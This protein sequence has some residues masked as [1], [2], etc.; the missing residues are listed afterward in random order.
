ML[1]AP[2]IKR[3][4]AALALL[5]LMAA[6]WGWLAD[7]RPTWNAPIS[8]AARYSHSSFDRWVAEDR[9]RAASFRDFEAFLSANGV[10]GVVPNWQLLRTDVNDR[11]GC[12]RPAFLLPPRG[13]WGHV[14]PALRLLREQIVP[15]IGPVEVVSSY[16]TEAF[17][18]CLGGAPQSRHLY[19]S[20][21]DLVTSTQRDNRSLF[22]E[23]CRLHRQLGPDSRF[24]LGAYFDPE[25]QGNNR[26]GRFH[27]DATGY[28]SWGSS[29]KAASSGCR[30]LNSA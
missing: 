13:K 29:K 25:K 17:N 9:A 18:S 7:R 14:V 23:L 20:A 3:L 19:F 5:L 26:R 22:V 24:G 11:L 8:S 12:P 1:K 6:V 21:L 2:W 16:R 10:S 28:R 15:A 4:I 27:I 30:L